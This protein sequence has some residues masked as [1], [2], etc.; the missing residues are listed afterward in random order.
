[1]IYEYGEPWWNDIDSGNLK[2]SE[3]HLSQCHIVHHKS[4]MDL[5]GHEPRPVWWEA[6]N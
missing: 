3:I 1:M 6:G 5:P 2:N 4:N